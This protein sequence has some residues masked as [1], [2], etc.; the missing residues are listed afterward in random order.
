[1]GAGRPRESAEHFKLTGG[2][3]SKPRTKGN[4]EPQV[5][6]G[7]PRCPAHVKA[8]P[9]AFAAFKDAVR[10]L[11]KRRTLSAGDAVTLT[12]YARVYSKF[13]RANDD[14]NER[15]FE[16]E[17]TKTGKDGNPYETT[18]P[19]PCVL[20]ATNTERQLLQ[21]AKS[22]GL[23]PDTRERVKPTKPT[24]GSEPVSYAPG[25]LGA[26][27]QFTKKGVPIC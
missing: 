2:K 8:D 4:D 23:T 17:V 3:P 7:R 1:M 9:V 27:V 13:V 21:L 18:I 11:R 24:E 20:I 19:N 14:V 6:A 5:F 25:T 12:V 22:L 15:G 10:L 26:L 16:I